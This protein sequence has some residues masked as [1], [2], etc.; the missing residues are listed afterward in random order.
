MK[1]LI[2]GLALMG[3]V[4]TSLRA[5]DPDWW[6]QV[7]LKNAQAADD[8]AGAN[9]GQLKY[10]AAKAADALNARTVDGAGS[11]INGLVASWN[12]VPGS[13]VV[14]DDYAALTAGQLKAISK[15]FYQR[16]AILRISSGLPA[17]PFPWSGSAFASD[18]WAMVNLGQMKYVFSF[19]IPAYSW[20]GD[21][22]HDLMVDT[23]ETSYVGG[24]SASASGDADG[25]TLSNLAE[26]LLWQLG[27]NPQ[28]GSVATAS[29]ASALGLTVYRP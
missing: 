29:P 23:W 5:A 27:A 20:A 12:Q 6:A 25:D 11:V 22:D 18:D 1:K 24:A 2:A 8:Y 3:A 17:S 14:R 28:P 19:N 15:L 10:S 7:G 21:G 16:L 4:L 9:L 26:H 13:G